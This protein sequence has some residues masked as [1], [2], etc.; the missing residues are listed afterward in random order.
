MPGPFFQPGYGLPGAPANAPTLRG[1]SPRQAEDS[2]ACDRKLLRR[3]DTRWGAAGGELPVRNK[4][5]AE[6][7]AT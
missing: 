2:P 1:G 5:A 3:G 4:A 7:A 6:A